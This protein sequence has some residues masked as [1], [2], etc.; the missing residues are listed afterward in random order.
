MQI[1]AIN[2][3]PR[4]RGNTA[5][6]LDRI[7][8]GAESRGVK[9]EKI[10][11]SELKINFCKEC[12]TVRIA[13][14]CNMK[15]D[16]RIIFKK[17][18]QADVII[19]GSPIFFGSLTGQLKTMIDRFQCFWLAKYIFKKNLFRDH[20]K[21]IGVF[22]SCSAAERKDFFS[23]AKAIIKNFFATISVE[24]KYEFFCGGIDKKGDILEHS[25]II[26]KAFDLGKRIS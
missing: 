14:L 13:S 10:N 20:K 1:L 21:R 6:L 25:D 17:I 8:E 5:I 12:D 7:L 2:G 23:N 11:L 18:K 15:D 26:K 24:Y 16:M 3:S 22:V 4:I 9:I 19:I